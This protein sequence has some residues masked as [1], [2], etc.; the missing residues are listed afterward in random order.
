[1]G[2]P[3]IPFRSIECMVCALNSGSWLYIYMM[4]YPINR[5]NWSSI[6]MINKKSRRYIFYF[7]QKQI[8]YSS[9]LL[10]LQAFGLY[11]VKLPYLFCISWTRSLKSSHLNTLS[12]KFPHF[13]KNSSANFSISILSSTD[14]YWSTSFL[15]VVFG[16]I[17][18]VMRSNFFPD[19]MISS[20]LSLKSG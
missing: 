15:P 12:N 7:F 4:W 14:A 3:K 5:S 17:S 6:L 11:S 16:A 13:F 2:A 9:K 8:T 18:E 1:M 20:I 10:S 19:H